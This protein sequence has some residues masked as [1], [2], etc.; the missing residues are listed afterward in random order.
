MR[1]LWANW[2]NRGNSEAGTG[3]KACVLAKMED[4]GQVKL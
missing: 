4:Y 3:Y 2:G 1:E